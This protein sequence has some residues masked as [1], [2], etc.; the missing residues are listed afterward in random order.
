MRK[1]LP[2]LAV[3]ALT[4]AALV[5][6]QMWPADAPASAAPLLYFVADT[7]HELTRLPVAFTRL[8]DAQEIKIGNE[9]AAGYGSYGAPDPRIQPVSEVQSVTAYVGRIGARLAP[10]A[11]RK[12]PY[13]FHFIPNMHFINAFAVPGGHVF[14]GDGLMGLME[15]EDE[16]ASVIGHEL[17]HIDHYH[18]AERVQI[19]MA[20]RR[21]PLG[22]LIALPAEI[23][24][25]GYS[26]QQELEADREGTRLAVDAGYSPE[27]SLRVFE[28]FQRLYEKYMKERGKPPSTP[29]EEAARVAVDV[30]AGYFRSH[31]RNSERL[32][33]IRQMIRAER[34]DT[35]KRRPQPLP[36]QYI[37]VTQRARAAL[38]SGRYDDAIKLAYRAVE[39]KPNYGGALQ[40]LARVQFA[41]ADFEKA[42]A[43]YRS[44]LDRYPNDVDSVSEYAIALSPAGD[45]ARAAQKFSSWIDRAQADAKTLARAKADLAGL[46][47][48]A[49]DGRPAEEALADL[50]GTSGWESAASLA[51]LGH[52]YYLAANYDQA[53]QVLGEAVEQVPRD[54]LLLTQLGWTFIEQ[55]KFESAMKRFRP[56]GLEDKSSNMGVAVVSWQTGQKDFALNQF[57]A[58]IA[59][60][61]AWLKPRWVHAL[62]GPIAAQ[63]VAEMQA[64][65]IKRDDASEQRPSGPK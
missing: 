45:H 29:Q 32:A 28:S 38:Y 25:A 19:E 57:G 44:L 1:R 13:Q 53:A 26:K 36:V 22:G 20:L 46:K 41:Q 39:L 17:E 64:E 8:S 40:T 63:S 55:R 51:R 47:L 11:H 62:F 43:T 59:V 7:E 42:A 58:A 14:V 34:W 31:P 54:E 4:A 18:C 61:P 33:Q 65:K 6:S 49:G 48:L 10:H 35:L 3:I 37:F 23:F 50:R 27:G 12:L 52:W 24:V 21:I 30:L 56:F 5:S 9:I 15:T 60:Q 2:W 16:L